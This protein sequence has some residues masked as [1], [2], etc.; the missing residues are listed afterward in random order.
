MS[1]RGAVRFAPATTSNLSLHPCTPAGQLWWVLRQLVLTEK[2]VEGA[3]P[4]V[5]LGQE[6]RQSEDVLDGCDDR[7][8]VVLRRRRRA[9][10]ALCHHKQSVGNRFPVEIEL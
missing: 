7:R 8:A 6:V 1:P 10:R 3:G 9:G 4:G 2:P 5:P